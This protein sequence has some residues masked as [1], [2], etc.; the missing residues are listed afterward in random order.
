M[1]FHDTLG[2]KVDVSDGVATVTLDAEDRHLNPHGFVHGGVLAALA[3]IAMAAALNETTGPDA[4]PVTVSL[5]MTYLEPA[6]A[7]P[8]TATGTITRQGKRITIAGAEI[9]SPDGTS[10]ASAVGTFTTV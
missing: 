8:T 2:I 6:P 4:A 1:S 3:D 9:T 5:V 10:V 7:G